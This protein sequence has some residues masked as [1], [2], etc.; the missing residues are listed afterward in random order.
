MS[1]PMIKPMVL[2]KETWQTFLKTWDTTVRYSAWYIA[3]AAVS[4][5]IAYLR[6]GRPGMQFIGGILQIVAVIAS[7]YLSVLLYKVVFAIEDKTPILPASKIQIWKIIGQTLI[8]GLIMIIP[9]LLCIGL[10]MLI[11]AFSFLD[12]AGAGNA[13][14]ILLTFVTIIAFIIAVTYVIGVRLSFAQNHIVDQTKGAIEGLKYS[15]K[16]TQNKFWAIFGRTMLAGLIFG[17]L[18]IALSIVAMII[19]SLVS[20]VDIATAMSKD[21]PSPAISS[22]TELVQGI[23]MAG[24]LPLF[25][26]FKVKLYREVEKVN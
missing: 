26:I 1:Q 18:A 15:W 13:L 14:G 4:A 20:G 22:M 17:T 5:T 6:I 23:V 21:N 3:L 8:S 19:V 9:M 2:I 11:G 25:Y 12:R 24:I 7:L 10:I 16:I